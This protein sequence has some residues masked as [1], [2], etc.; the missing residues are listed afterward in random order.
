MRQREDSEEE[1][2][3]Q[4]STQ[5]EIKD[6]RDSNWEKLQEIKKIHFLKKKINHGINAHNLWTVDSKDRSMIKDDSKKKGLVNELDLGNTFSVETNRRDEDAD[7]LKYIEEQLAKK[8]GIVSEM[9]D[10]DKNTI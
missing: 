6:A 7:M 10:D 2:C 5:N 3:E 1:M 9:M 4:E 8:K